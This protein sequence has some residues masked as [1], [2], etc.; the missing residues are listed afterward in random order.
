VAPNR[1]DRDFTAA[2]PNQKWVGDITGVW[3]EAGW[4]YLS[5]LENLYSRRIVGWSILFSD[6]L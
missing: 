3:T 4:F 5:A 1:L 2:A 6:D